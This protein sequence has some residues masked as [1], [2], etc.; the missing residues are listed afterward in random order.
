METAQLS[1]FILACQFRN[2]AEAATYSQVPPSTMSENN[3]ALERELGL[4]LFQRGPHGHYPTEAARW[5][6]QV[7]EPL[8]Q[9]VQAAQGI[10]AQP[11]LLS[12]RYLDVTSPLQFMVGHLARTTS[13]A[14]AALMRSM[15]GVVARAHFALSRPPYIHVLD[16]HQGN[17]QP[18]VVLNYAANA[19]EPDGAVILRDEWIS[20]AGPALGKA[21]G[22]STLTFEALRSAPLYV[23]P[24]DPVQLAQIRHYCRAHDLPPPRVI[25]EDVGTFERL[26]REQQPFHLLAPRSLVA[27]S[28]ERSTLRPQRLPVDLA[29]VIVAHFS[30][31]D[32][33]AA[34]FVEHLR[35]II[36]TDNPVIAYKPGITIRQLR[37][38]LAVSERL[39]V[40]ATA[41][42]LH[43]AQP[44][45]SSQISKLEATLGMTLFQR[46]RKGLIPC[47]SAHLL[48][49]LMRPALLACEGITAAASYYAACREER[50]T[51]GITPVSNHDAPLAQGLALTIAAWTQRY[52]S[53]KLRITEGSAETLRC[54]VESGE[55]GF[56]IVAGEG[57]LSRVDALGV[58]SRAQ[59]PISKP[60][61]ITLS[62][63]LKLPL[64]LPGPEVDLR[65]QLN[66]A[67]AEIAASVTPAIEVGSQSL[68]LALV[69]QMPLAAIMPASAVTRLVAEGVL[70]FNPIC[71]PHLT[72]GLS[73]LCPDNR[74]LT[75][76][77]QDLLAL[78]GEY[79]QLEP[80]QL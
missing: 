64:V 5:L 77:E 48:R 73:F 12:L 9:A 79:L 30:A 50:L 72:Y 18:D 66:K 42:Q 8:L 26:S 60:G 7:V 76:M 28:A 51:I 68:I 2:H 13:L 38:F 34:C 31:G 63:A 45:L 67:A 40:T 47:D 80:N 70:Q 27:A 57:D 20:L 74:T 62:E 3:H 49:D 65:Q 16:K 22:A 58:I 69:K 29:A 36:T 53:V 4:T 35:A 78:L 25:E 15:P 75:Q 14:I 39:N 46:S 24:L 19:D 33:V 52:P 61:A 37:Y 17:E 6:Y 41:R 59:H 71:A 44:A 11:D 54:W 1:Y 43:V 32:E 23:P 55:V 10:V 21:P 56:A